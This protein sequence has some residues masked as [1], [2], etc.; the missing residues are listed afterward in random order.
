MKN[1]QPEKTEILIIGAG[2]T[3]LLAAID[4]QNAG[5]QTVVVDKGRGV[6]GRLA[7]RRIGSATFDHGAQFITTRTPRFTSLIKEWE[8]LGLVSE[9]FRSEKSDHIH[10][11]GTP[12]M[13][14]IPKHL[15]NRLDVRLEKKITALQ[16][17]GDHWLATFEDGES[18]TATNFLI[19]APLPQSLAILE[20]GGVVLEDDM[21]RKLLD[22]EYEPCLAVMAV[23]SRDSNIPQPGFIRP[24]SGP[25]AWIA[26]NKTKGVSNSPAITIHATPAFSSAHWLDD[27]E[28]IANE[29]LAT[30]APWIGSEI[31]EYQV[32]GWRYARP[33]REND[34][35]FV[36]IS[37]QPGLIIAGDVFG[38]ARVEG[39]ALSGWAAAG[40]IMK[41]Q[42]GASD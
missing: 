31:V 13:T 11:R 14:S 1:S 17:A 36:W 23:L 33:M 15:A 3:G 38:G 41:L 20:A 28:K 30:A 12:T 25:I 16:K 24:A 37:K 6:G 2:L 7:S 32:H 27:R 10:W 8:S 29:L 42:R 22:L 9:W 4:L 18:I 35:M 19:T 21:N 39:A 26:D 40:A 5:Y 34:E